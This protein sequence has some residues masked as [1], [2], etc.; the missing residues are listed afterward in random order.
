LWSSKKKEGNIWQNFVFLATRETHC[1]RPRFTAL[2]KDSGGSLLKSTH[3]T[4]CQALKLHLVTRFEWNW[5]DTKNCLFLQGLLITWNDHG[6]LVV[7][8]PTCKALHMCK[9]FKCSYSELEMTACKPLGF[10][11]SLFSNHGVTHL[12]PLLYRHNQ[13]ILIVAESKGEKQPWPSFIKTQRSANTWML[14]IN[15]LSL[16]WY[17]TWPN[18]LKAV[19]WTFLNISFAYCRLYV[20]Y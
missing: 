13:V 5:H 12:L 20:H 18:N 3:N 14:E 7:G 10:W 17:Y 6:R 9:G 1:C 15:Y 16:L 8:G 2:V 19:E 11:A 4:I